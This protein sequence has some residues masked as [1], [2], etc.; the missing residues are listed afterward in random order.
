M[1][2][3]SFPLGRQAEVIKSHFPLDLDVLLVTLK[4]ISVSLQHTKYVAI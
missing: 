2:H 1:A 4:G 3:T